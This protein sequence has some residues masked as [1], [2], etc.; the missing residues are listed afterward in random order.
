MTCTQYILTEDEITTICSNFLIL[1]MVTY[2]IKVLIGHLPLM[3]DPVKYRVVTE[4]TK[5]D[6]A[7]NN[8]RPLV[9]ALF[10]L[11]GKDIREEL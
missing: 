4:L 8:L 2:D 11:Q 7:L 9:T 1:D 5:M 6:S 10:E 3:D